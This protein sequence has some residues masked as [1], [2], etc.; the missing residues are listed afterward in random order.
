M[1]MMQDHPDTAKEDSLRWGLLQIS[2]IEV[3]HT[4]ASSPTG[5]SKSEVLPNEELIQGWIA[6]Q[7]AIRRTASLLCEA[8][9]PSAKA[10][11][12]ERT[13]AVE[14]ILHTAVALRDDEQSLVR[15]SGIQGGLAAL[16]VQTE[17]QRQQ[18]DDYYRASGTPGTSLHPFATVQVK[19]ST[20][21]IITE[22]A[23]TTQQPRLAEALRRAGVFTTPTTKEKFS[24]YLDQKGIP[25]TARDAMADAVFISTKSENR[26]TRV[27]PR[28]SAI[29]D[30]GAV[31]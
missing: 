16:H 12:E 19:E 13:A 24:E 10:T 14:A 3:P 4:E 8:M 21:V 26:T 17:R 18:L 6:D 20:P 5:S 28:Y 1:V 2:G 11:H 9:R 23:L 15:R 30:A 27:Y 7:M 22:S 29:Y 25:A 31:Q